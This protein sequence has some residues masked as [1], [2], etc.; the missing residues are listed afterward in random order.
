MLG[1]HGAGGETGICA[2]AAGLRMRFGPSS[3]FG[4]TRASGA[5]RKMRGGA[6]GVAF[7]G[8]AATPRG[9]SE[10]SRGRSSGTDPKAGFS[11]PLPGT[12]AETARR[13]LWLDGRLDA[14]EVGGLHEPLLACRPG[15]RGTDQLRWLI[16]RKRFGAKA[17]GL[18]DRDTETSR[19]SRGETT[20]PS[21]TV[22]T[23][24]F[25]GPS[26]APSSGTEKCPCVRRALWTRGVEFAD[27]TVG[28][29]VGD[30]CMTSP[31]GEA[32]RLCNEGSA[33]PL[34]EWPGGMT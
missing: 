20:F 1:V 12:R 2:P 26:P 16:P 21:E 15:A 6:G 11:P 33:P 25:I 31:L 14:W 30:G 34:G 7:G 13:G 27:T 32:L 9:G 18:D 10:R 8:A 28:G 22:M 5:A 24:A 4:E 19:P 23:C 17:S 29:T 3:R